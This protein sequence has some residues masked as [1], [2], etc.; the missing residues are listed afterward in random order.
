MATEHSLFLLGVA[1]FS[2]ILVVGLILLA[3]DP[4]KAQLP[5]L[6][7]QQVQLRNSGVL[8]AVYLASVLTLAIILT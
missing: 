4:V 8:V 6:R 2:A 1:L 3:Y 5:S 7:Q